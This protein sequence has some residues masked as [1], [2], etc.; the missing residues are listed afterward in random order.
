MEPCAYTMEQIK[1]MQNVDIRTVD[2]A[3]LRD[4]REV[5][6]NIDLPKRERILD[7]IRQIGN[8]YCYRHGKYVVKVS[9]TDTDV[10]LEDRMLSYIRSKC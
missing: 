5:K 8:P 9:F 7:F 1:A 6:V 4:I 3:G 2:P 10:T